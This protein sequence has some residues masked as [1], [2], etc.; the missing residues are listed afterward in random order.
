MESSKFEQQKRW[1]KPPGESYFKDP[2]YFRFKTNIVNISDKD[3]LLGKNPG[4]VVKKQK[5]ME[6]LFCK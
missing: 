4:G 2:P 1:P 6:S 5:E 3:K